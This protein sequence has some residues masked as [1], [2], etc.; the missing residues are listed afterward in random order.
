MVCR[1]AAQ[2]A[3]DMWHDLDHSVLSA[4]IE[5]DLEAAHWLQKCKR[6]IQDLSLGR[7]GG[8]EGEVGT[9]LHERAR[10]ELEKHGRARGGILDRYFESGGRAQSRISIIYLRLFLPTETE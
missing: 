1:G 3:A 5:S 7:K 6:R 10:G 9:T 4:I 8:K 2:L